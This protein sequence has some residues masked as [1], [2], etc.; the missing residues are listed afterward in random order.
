[1]VDH[2]FEFIK[3]LDIDVNMLIHIG[4]DGPNVNK[5]FQSK[6]KTKFLETNK[7]ILDIGTCNLHPVH[8]AFIKG[9]KKLD[10]D[11]E[12]LVYELNIF[13][14]YSSARRKDYKL[15]SLVTEV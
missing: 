2:F 7:Q 8:T 1:M 6:L 11:F 4:M 9:L 14:K 10:F 15:C 5:S 12:K 13:S 3:K